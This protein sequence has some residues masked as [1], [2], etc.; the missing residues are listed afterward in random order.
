VLLAPVVEDGVVDLEALVAGLLDEY[1]VPGAVVGVVDARGEARIAN[2][3]T[4]GGGRGPV[5]DDTV[6]AAASLTKPVFASGVMALV[7]AGGLDLDRPLIDYRPRPYVMGDDRAAAITARMV[8][9]HTTGFPNWREDGPLY[10]RWS[11]GT[12]WGYSGEGYAYLHQVVEHLT[13]LRLDHYLADAVLGPLA[14]HDSNLGSRHE[15]DQ[16]VAF[17]HD[18]G[19]R[20]QPLDR[21]IES[22]V[23][24]GGLYTTGPDYLRFLVH[25]LTHHHLMFEPQVRIDDE[26]AWGLGWGI[27]DT[28]AG[29]AVWQWGND[30]GYKNFVIG[31]PTDGRGVVVFT[32]GDRGALV[33]RHL[34]RQ[35]LPGP[36]PALEARRRP[37]WL[38]AN[39]PRPVDLRPRLDEPAVRPLL[40]L[41][42]AGDDAEVADIADR[43]RHPDPQLLGLVVESSWESQDA[44]AGTPVACLGLEPRDDRTE[45]TITSLAVV[46]GWRRQGFARALIFGACEHLGLRAVETQTDADAVGFYRAIGFSVSSLGE[47]YRGIERFRCR[48]DLPQR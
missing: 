39:S 37:T 21:A 22:K 10:L 4:R 47:Q 25:A 41:L 11:P 32:N 19:G 46:P 36:H 43:Y 31:R 33:Y 48:L 3:G 28:N 7:G 14:M 44:A 45:A 34:V 35:L 30:P 15:Q 2:G 24:A 16:R 38:L 27:E 42:A 40:A 17:G 23:A 13:G 5:D 6:F 9:S 18:R 12:R 8:L 1:D 29:R 20:P 26:L